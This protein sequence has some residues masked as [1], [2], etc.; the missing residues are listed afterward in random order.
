MRKNFII[1]I[2]SLFST[3]YSKS[4]SQVTVGA[5]KPPEEFSIIEVV[6]DG[7]GGF[8]LPQINKKQRD[9]LGKKILSMPEVTNEEKDKKSRA[10]GLTIFNT[11][12]ELIEYWNGFNWYTVDN[13]PSIEPEITGG[14]IKNSQ[15][16]LSNSYYPSGTINDILEVT[17]IG[18]NGAYY[19][20]GKPYK[21]TDG[22]KNITL[23]L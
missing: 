12:S 18:G 3:F 19:P 5:N 10:K 4:Y 1:V 2:I 8:R 23:E 15:K 13:T 6:S 21:L 17:Y 20:T 11:T 16:L 7:K 22:G 9:E 14:L